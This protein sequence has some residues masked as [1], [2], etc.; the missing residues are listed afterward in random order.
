MKRWK[1][2]KCHCNDSGRC[3]ACLAASY[4]RALLLASPMLA[5]CS[6]APFALAGVDVDSSSPAEGVGPQEGN[7]SGLQDTAPTRG[8]RYELDG[9]A[10][11]RAYPS[12]AGAVDASPDVA[13]QPVDDA[14]A[15]ALCCIGSCAGYACDPPCPVPS[16]HQRCSGAA[17]CLVV[18]KSIGIDL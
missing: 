3:C 8:P 17:T 7:E 18:C 10:M 9:G 2:G 13:S 11:L 6:G 16:L 15:P 5:G 14:A 12:D 1:L 4:L